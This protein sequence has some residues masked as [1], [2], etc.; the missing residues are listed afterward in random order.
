MPITTVVADDDVRFRSALCAVLDDDERFT[1]LGAVG[2]ADEAVAAVAE[3]TPQ[4]VVLD[5][6]MP[7]GGVSAAN[8]ITASGSRAAI[9]AMSAKVDATLVAAL[10]HGGAR[11]VCVKGRLGASVAALLARCTSGEIVLA[12]PA[13]SDGLRLY[14]DQQLAKHLTAGRAVSAGQA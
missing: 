1:V 7:G 9:V 8:A 6:Q 5:V 14:V 11:G 12:T 13:A 4:L 3:H 10:L 2:S